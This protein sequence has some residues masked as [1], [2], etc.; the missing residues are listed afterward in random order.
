MN[1]QPV[2]LEILL[3]API[4]VGT[5]VDVCVAAE[6]GLL[7]DGYPGTWLQVVETGIIY[8]DVVFYRKS[9]AMS[10]REPPPALEV[11]RDLS[12][13]GRFRGRVIYCRVCAVESTRTTTTLVVQPEID[14]TPYR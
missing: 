8:T 9:S 11:R 14:G 5:L 10:D 4:P 2:R 7:G 1:L 12:V 3:A 6:S 13:H